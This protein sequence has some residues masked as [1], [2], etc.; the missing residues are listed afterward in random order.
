M[1]TTGQGAGV[2][3]RTVTVLSL[4]VLALSIESGPS[5]EAGLL[6]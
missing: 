5:H 6:G 4:I 2:S 3:M 1:P